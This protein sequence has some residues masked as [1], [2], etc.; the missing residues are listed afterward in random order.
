VRGNRHTPKFS[1]FFHGHLMGLRYIE[2]H[3][4]MN[5]RQLCRRA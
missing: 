4:N 1:F 2:G 3:T 5:H